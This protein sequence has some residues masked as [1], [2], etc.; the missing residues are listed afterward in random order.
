[1]LRQG[2][3]LLP[4]RPAYLVSSLVSTVGMNE[5]RKALAG[6][7]GTHRYL[8][9][10]LLVSRYYAKRLWGSWLEWGT[11]TVANGKSVD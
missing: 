4:T 1:M 9:V 6:Q 3:P 10:S 2:I 7:C 5:T 8:V 11:L